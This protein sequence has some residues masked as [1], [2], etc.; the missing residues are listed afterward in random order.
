MNPSTTSYAPNDP[1]R[2]LAE[3]STEINWS[4]ADA[5]PY[6]VL[7]EILWKDAK[8]TG[9]K[10]PEPRESGITIPGGKQTKQPDGD[11]D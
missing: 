1:R 6:K 11:G 5:D 10:M 9:S 4:I 7:N 8:G 2:R 3:L